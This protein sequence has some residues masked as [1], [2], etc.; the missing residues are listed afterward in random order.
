MQPCTL[1]DA[2]RITKCDSKN[3]NFRLTTRYTL[4]YKVLHRGSMNHPASPSKL[5]AYAVSEWLLV[6][7]AI[8][9]LGAAALRQ[10]QPAEREPARTISMIFSLIGPRISHFDAAL[11][12]LGLPGI[13]AISGCGLAQERDFAAGYRHH[14]CKPS[15]ESGRRDSGNGDVARR[16]HS[17]CR[18]HSHHYRL[19][20]RCIRSSTALA[21]APSTGRRGRA[22]TAPPKRTSHNRKRALQWA[23][24]GPRAR[25]NR[26]TSQ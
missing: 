15:P 24:L 6:L 9:L 1:V 4:S 19:R 20:P 11:L 13:A 3:H 18:S 2:A 10:L 16:R 17:C 5:F 23:T 8:L 7:P 21:R 26:K 25:I 12:F 22:S 14:A